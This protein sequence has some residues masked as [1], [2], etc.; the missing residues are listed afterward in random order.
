MI[1]V[2]HCVNVNITSMAFAP[3]VASV[4]TMP[5]IDIYF[6][7]FYRPFSVHWTEL[8]S[9]VGGRAIS[10]CGVGAIH[11]RY[12]GSGQMLKCVD[13]SSLG[14]PNYYLFF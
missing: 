6:V 14:I 1:L 4:V 11:E 13:Q 12:H 8:E 10:N 9:S 3:Y 2:K 7:P 5:N